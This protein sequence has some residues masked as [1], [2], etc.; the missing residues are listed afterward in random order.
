MPVRRTILVSVNGIT[1]EGELAH[2][3]GLYT[4]HVHR[5]WSYLTPR[6]DERPR[7][8]L[9]HFK[10]DNL[11]RLMSDL[12]EAGITIWPSEWRAF[13]EVGMASLPL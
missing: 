11:N 13:R 3:G 9:R 1:H 10:A 12:A 4:L 6:P 5:A 2:D 8:I 7:G